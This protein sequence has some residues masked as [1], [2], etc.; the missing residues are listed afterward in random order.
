M[1]VHSLNFKPVR[2][3]SVLGDGWTTDEQAKAPRSS[4]LLRPHPNY[5][6]KHWVYKAAISR[7][8]YMYILT[9][10]YVY[11]ILKICDAAWENPAKVAE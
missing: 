10:L 11:A 7:F 6:L 9:H 5:A 2:E 1:C 8:T 3:L 4:I